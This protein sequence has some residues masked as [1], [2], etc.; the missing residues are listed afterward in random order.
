M[1]LSRTLKPHA[2]HTRRLFRK[3]AL[4]G[5]VSFILFISIL[6]SLTW[7]KRQ[8]QHELLLQHSVDDLQQ[9][10]SALTDTLRPLQQYTLL[11][12]NSVSRELT[13]RAAFADNI[14]AILL[15][16]DGL[17]YCSSA[18]GAFRLPA[19]E[20]SPATDLESDRDLRLLPGTPLLPSRPALA[21]WLKY[22][23]SAESGIMTTINLSLAPYQLLASYYPEIT[24]MALVIG[25]D[26][27]KSD[28][29]HTFPR[30]DLP[31][32]LATLALPQSDIRFVL[33]GST[34]AMRDYQMTLLTGVLFALMIGCLTGVLLNRR[35]RPAREIMLA[36][37]RGQFYVEYQPLI[38]AHNEQPYGV[39]ALLR[40]AH[41]IE[42][43][44]PPDVFISYAEAQNLI[45]PLTR[46]LFHLVARDAHTLSQQLPR[47]TRLSL[48]L[49]PL[50]LAADSFRHDVRTWLAGMPADHFSY[51]FEITERTMV[52]ET[53]AGEVFAWLH[54][55]QFSIAIDDFGTGHSAL[56]YLEKYPFDYLKIDRG[57]VQSIGTETLTSPV[58]DAVLLLAKK[59]NLKT[60]A[61]GV[62]TRE[63][64]S[65]LVSRGVTHLQ[66]YLFSRPL[67]PEK[68]VSYYQNF[69]HFG[70]GDI[71][72]LTG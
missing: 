19:S 11:D 18:T 41:P 63:Q 20:I 10:L 7:H 15:V 42:G 45:I 16:R 66:G 59:L 55:N 1:P 9:M 36:I 64:A 30:R 65:W 49:S 37:R 61:E 71:N 40:W 50:H 69:P 29:S 27:L 26:A 70:Y 60:V 43:A 14:R 47:G 17:A 44:I 53:N 52:R 56:I 5:M 13:S 23:G 8:Q 4:A 22:P 3:S 67:R 57:F 54:A 58:L 39:E 21:L 24:G 48:N 31:A 72:T 28:V 68:L 2:T 38:T 12:C 25:N 62:E 6:L 46:H 34:L 32:G 51:V 35:Q 33:Y